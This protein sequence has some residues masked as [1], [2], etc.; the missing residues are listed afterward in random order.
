MALAHKCK[1]TRTHADDVPRGNA[2][3]GDDAQRQM[4][5]DMHGD[6]TFTLERDKHVPLLVSN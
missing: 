5:K 1:Y 2:L 4:R 6:D 3:H